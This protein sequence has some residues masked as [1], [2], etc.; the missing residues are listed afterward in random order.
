MMKC[1]RCGMDGVEFDL[2]DLMGF[3]SASD[4]TLCIITA[5]IEFFRRNMQ[6]LEQMSLKSA[7]GISYIPVDVMISSL[8][9]L[10]LKVR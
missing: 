8:T 9:P 5:F 7:C 4:T 6:D 10:G 1:M 3:L 2:K